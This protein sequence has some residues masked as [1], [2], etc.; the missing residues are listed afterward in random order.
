MEALQG[1]SEANSSPAG[2]HWLLVQRVEHNWVRSSSYER[3]N[4][5]VRRI[6]NGTD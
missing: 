4:D 3:N 5:C 1:V 2:G 6:T